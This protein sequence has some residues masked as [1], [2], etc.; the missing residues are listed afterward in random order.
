MV[1]VFTINEVLRDFL[2]Q[3]EK[4][5]IK[6]LDEN[7]ELPEENRVHH[8]LYKRFNI[9][10]EEEVDKFNKF[11]YDTAVLPCFGYCN[12]VNVKSVLGLN[13][14]RPVRVECVTYYTLYI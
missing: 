13:E 3:V 14:I 11:L 5:I 4:S 1:I 2:N 6:Y 8:E 10:T 9:N 12:L 7:F